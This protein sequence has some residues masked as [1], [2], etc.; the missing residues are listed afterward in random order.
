MSILHRRSIAQPEQI[1]FVAISHSLFSVLERAPRRSWNLL[2]VLS[3]LHAWLKIADGNQLDLL[4]LREKITEIP[5]LATSWCAVVRTVAKGVDGLKPPA[6]CLGL[7]A[8]G[9][10]HKTACTR[11]PGSQARRGSTLSPR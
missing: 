3:L 9:T 4:E 1:E 11:L 6:C 8:F 5:A 2:A 10:C 7:E